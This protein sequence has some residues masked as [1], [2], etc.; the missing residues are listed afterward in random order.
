M[1]SPMVTIKH[2]SH[3]TAAAVS[4]TI[5]VQILRIARN[6]HGPYLVA[7]Q[8]LTAQHQVT[9]LDKTN[10]LWWGLL[11]EHRLLLQN[12]CDNK[13][14]CQSPFS[15]SLKDLGPQ[16]CV[17][18]FWLSQFQISIVAGNPGFGWNV[19]LF[20]E[21]FSEAAGELISQKLKFTQASNSHYLL[22]NWIHFKSNFAYIHTV[23]STHTIVG[24]YIFSSGE[25]LEMKVRF[26]ICISG[27]YSTQKV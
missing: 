12:I 20:T 6:I 24:V 17:Q 13:C 2:L 14:S 16:W 5:M 25:R 15:F 1:W 8:L 3:G 9:L 7:H 19:Q 4:R 11:A 21:G 27:V 23:N 10:I 18:Y 22:Q 26:P